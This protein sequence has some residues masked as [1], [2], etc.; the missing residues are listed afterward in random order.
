M[1]LKRVCGH[2]NTRAHNV[3]NKH[4]ARTKK[5]SNIF[6]SVYKKPIKEYNKTA[7]IYER[8]YY[9]AVLCDHLQ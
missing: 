5:L 4:D 8:L 3:I 7:Q 9:T 2:D 6:L 1:A